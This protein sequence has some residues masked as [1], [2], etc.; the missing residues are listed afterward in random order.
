MTS[1]QVKLIESNLKALEKAAQE[2]KGA[3]V[4]LKPEDFQA[5]LEA[6]SMPITAAKKK[7]LLKALDDGAK[8]LQMSLTPKQVGSGFFSALLKGVAQVAIPAI[9]EAGANALVNKI[10]RGDGGNTVGVTMSD[11]QK[12]KMA[13]CVRRAYNASSGKECVLTIAAKNMFGDDQLPVNSTQREMINGKRLQDKGIRLVFSPDDMKNYQEGGFL[14]ALLGLAIPAITSIFAPRGRGDP[15]RGLDPSPEEADLSG[16]G[17]R[18]FGQG[19][20]LLGK[21]N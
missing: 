11:Y 1:V 15:S 4:S 18:P 2:G 19:L 5:G 17:I 3:T 6:V 10:G 14:G 12:K 9:A 8:E 20:R 21:K 13:S 7:K 16:E